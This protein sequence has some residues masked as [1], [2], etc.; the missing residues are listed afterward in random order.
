MFKLLLS[1]AL[2]IPCFVMAFSGPD[3]AK[4]VEY[5]FTS[6]DEYFI[7]PVFQDLD[8]CKTSELDVFFHNEYITMH[9]AEYLAEALSRS[10]DCSGAK[11]VILPIEPTSTRAHGLKQ[12]EL[13]AAQA[14]E[15][16]LILEAH[17]VEASIAPT[18]VEDEFN[19][20]S[21]NGRNAILKII[22]EDGKSA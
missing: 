11:Y 12:E 3:Q 2:S 13:T 16:S 10:S 15:L 9:S 17:G 4:G 18:D 19:S 5:D 6:F 22:I 21:V 8:N 14:K 7:E 1:S 20:L